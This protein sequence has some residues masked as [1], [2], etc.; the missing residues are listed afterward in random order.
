MCV[1]CP[2]LPFV[3]LKLVFFRLTMWLF[4]RWSTELLKRTVNLSGHNSAG[5]LSRRITLK[6]NFQDKGCSGVC[7]ATPV[8]LVLERRLREED[9][10]EFKA[11]LNYR[12]DPNLNQLDGVKCEPVTPGD[13]SVPF[14]KSF[15][16]VF[17][18]P[19]RSS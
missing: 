14:L 19:L 13:R 16:T 9:R 4:S 1:T 2:A 5:P 10:H 6:G 8:F 12:G 17:Q 18:M 3:A 7:W 11:S 15:P